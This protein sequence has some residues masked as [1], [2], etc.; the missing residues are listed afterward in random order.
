MPAIEEGAQGGQHLDVLAIDPVA[1]QAVL[2]TLHKGF[3][4][5]LIEPRCDNENLTRKRCVA[6]RKSLGHV[7]QE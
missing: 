3:H 7:I 4:H 1:Y 6:A 5:K 2:R